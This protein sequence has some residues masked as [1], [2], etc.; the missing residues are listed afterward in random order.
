VTNIGVSL[1]LNDMW[2]IQY[3][4]FSGCNR[5]WQLLFFTAVYLYLLR[6]SFPR[7]IAPKNLLLYQIPKK[8]LPIHVWNSYRITEKYEANPKGF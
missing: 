2:Y 8:S 4:T 3:L 6:Y 7:V 1:S 5:H